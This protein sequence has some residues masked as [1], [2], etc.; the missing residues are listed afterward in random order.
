VGNS[1]NPGAWLYATPG[2]GVTFEARG[3]SGASKK[4]MSLP[5][6][7]PPL[8]LRLERAPMDPDVS[9]FT[10]AVSRDGTQ[11]TPAGSVTLPMFKVAAGLT[12]GLFAGSG[13]EDTLET[14]G[15]DNV[16]VEATP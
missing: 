13:N 7:K 10:A 2:G 1:N 11:W 15:F 12:A 14:A 5:D 16:T 4:V 9:V 6:L 8:W 3:F